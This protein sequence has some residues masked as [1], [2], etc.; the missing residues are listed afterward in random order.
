MDVSGRVMLGMGILSDWWKPLSPMALVGYSLSEE[1][2][3]AR[4]VLD[5][6]CIFNVR[7]SVSKDWLPIRP[8]GNRAMRGRRTFS[9]LSVCLVSL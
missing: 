5:K 1:E 2:E 4:S 8:S 3:G 6:G 9:P 7:R